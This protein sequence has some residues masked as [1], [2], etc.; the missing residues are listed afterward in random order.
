M[1]VNSERRGLGPP[2]GANSRVRS[3]V[4]LA[5]QFHDKRFST[6]AARAALLGAT[7]AHLESDTGRATFVLTWRHVTREFRRLEE[8][9]RILNV[10]GETP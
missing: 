10:M 2:A 8:V 5:H 4:P 3:T 1:D 9:E 6:A 7:L